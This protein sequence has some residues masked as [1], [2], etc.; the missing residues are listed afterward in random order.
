MVSADSFFEAVQ[1]RYNRFKLSHESGI[2]V[3]K[4][5]S[6]MSSARSVQKAVTP[7]S[8]KVLMLVE[9][10]IIGFLAFWVASEYTYSVYFRMYADQILISHITTY[11]AVLGLGI[12]L[13]GSVAAAMLYKNMRLAK[14]RLETVAVPKIRG[15]V[16]KVLANLPSADVQPPSRAVTEPAVTQPASQPVSP[17]VTAIVPIPE[18]NEQKKQSS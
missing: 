1:H 5:G 14:H 9:A 4:V 6:K 11:S 15:A 13:A 8:V 16:E 18:S 7:G 10:G 17:P 2:T 12:G 3:G